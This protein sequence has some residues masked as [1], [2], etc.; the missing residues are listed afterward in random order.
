MNDGK[1]LSNETLNAIKTGGFTRVIVVGGKLAVPDSVINNQLKGISCIRIAGANAI[2]TST[3]IAYFA[4]GEG[5]VRDHIAVA[6]TKDFAD[7]L[8]GAAL[9]GAQNSVL[10]LSNA[11]FSNSA[12]S[13]AFDSVYSSSE[14][15]HGHILGGN[16][17]LDANAETY[18]RNHA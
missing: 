10:I 8:T 9:A 6:T 17:A 1:G 4:M 18:F 2:A 5:M 14:L 11:S 3:E 13:A 12:G 15:V 16:F 7:A